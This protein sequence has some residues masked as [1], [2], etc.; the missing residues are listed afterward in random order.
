MICDLLCNAKSSLSPGS[1]VSLLK[2]SRKLQMEDGGI[3]FSKC[4]TH[5]DRP[6]VIWIHA[7]GRFVD[8][9]NNVVRPS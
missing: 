2:F 6:I 7:R 3:K 1:E 9:V 4:V 8:R 5:H